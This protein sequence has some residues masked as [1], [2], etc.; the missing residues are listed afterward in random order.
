MNFADPKVRE[1]ITVLA[2]LWTAFAG[3]FL[4]VVAANYR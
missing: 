2:T 3:A 4:L 1:K